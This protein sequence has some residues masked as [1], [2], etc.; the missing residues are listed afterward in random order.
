MRVEEPGGPDAV[1]IDPDHPVYQVNIYKRFNDPDIEDELRGY[2]VYEWKLHDSDVPEVLAWA[3]N[4]VGRAPVEV[5]V[6]A[7][8]DRRSQRR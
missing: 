7:G 4:S 3:G 1:T 6:A 8:A 2:H 5:G